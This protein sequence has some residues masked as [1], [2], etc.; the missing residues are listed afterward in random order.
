MLKV[1]SRRGF[2][3]TL[4]ATALVTGAAP[5][6]A[7]GDGG[8]GRKS[9]K[10]KSPAGTGKKKKS[11]FEIYAETVENNYTKKGMGYYFSRPS[12]MKRLLERMYQEQ[13]AGEKHI[14]KTLM[15]IRDRKIGK[16][17]NKKKYKPHLATQIIEASMAHNAYKRKT[18]AEENYQKTMIR[19]IGFVP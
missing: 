6:F 15:D 7:G 5:A 10:P 13:K 4:A 11:K 2:L 18:L 16:E 17:L 12:R 1:I 3:S 9:S 14:L 8:G 19:L